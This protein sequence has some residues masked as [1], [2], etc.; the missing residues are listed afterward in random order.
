M[1]GQPNGGAHAETGDR[2]R[3]LVL[4]TEGD[5]RRRT[6]AALAE[7]GAEALVPAGPAD[8]E[9]L[10][11]R[12]LLDLVVVGVA[13]GAPS[14]AELVCRLH[15]I[16]PSVPIVLV[17]AEDAAADAGGSGA[18][19]P[20]AYDRLRAHDAWLARGFARAIQHRRLTR[21][22]AALE[23][24]GGESLRAI[25]GDGPE[26]DAAVATVERVAPT[27]VH[28]VLHME[29]GCGEDLLARW[30]HRRS[31]HA[32]GAFITFDG[33]W[34]GAPA[35]GRG[36]GPGRGEAGEGHAPPGATLFLDGL[37]RFSPCDQ[38]R[39]LRALRARRATGGGLR[40]IAATAVA[41]EELLAAGRLKAELFR[42]VNEAVVVLRPLRERPDELAGLARRFLAE[43]ADQLGR[44]LGGF[45]EEALDLLLAYTWP[46]NAREL[47]AVVGRAAAA[48]RTLVGRGHLGA[49]RA[50]EGTPLTSP[51]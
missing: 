18:A 29:E 12:L 41:P 48:A 7:L 43:A 50:E 25:L 28:V 38:L 42:E 5:A 23:R 21:R 8:G 40:I 16:D 32:A 36:T 27:G 22:L 9:R 34:H 47:R 1:S 26:A 6:L 44:P 19:C 51:A 17:A 35:A 49:L 33:E 30:I 45:A 2:P 31:P 13:A 39:V 46:G 4:A 14:Q 10:A 24:Q 20:E 15:R 3:A 11:R 37:H